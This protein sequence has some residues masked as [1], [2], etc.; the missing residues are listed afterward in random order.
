MGS[1]KN[2]KIDVALDTQQRARTN[3][4]PRPEEEALRS[5]SNLI[6]WA[7]NLEIFDLF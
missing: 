7:I 4:L 2:R 1:L 3:T 6:L 5:P